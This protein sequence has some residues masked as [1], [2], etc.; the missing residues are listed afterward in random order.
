ME[1][2]G[3]LRPSI[4]KVWHKIFALYNHHL[5]LVVL[6]ACFTDALAR[7]IAETVDYAVGTSKGIG[8]KAAIAFAGAFYRALGF[9]KCVRHAFKS[10]NAELALTK[11]PRSRGIELFVKN[12]VGEK[13][14]FPGIDESRNV[15]RRAIGAN[16]VLKTETRFECHIT[17]HRTIQETVFAQ[18]GT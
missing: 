12:G 16:R 7:S 17:V 15:P 5:R 2:P 11:T 6:N 14:S 10:A 13:D 1:H 9:G 4:T 3:E 8:D 18:V